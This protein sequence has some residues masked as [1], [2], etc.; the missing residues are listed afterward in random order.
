MPGVEQVSNISSHTS[1]RMN[2]SV[3]LGCTVLG[4]SPVLGASMQFRAPL[5][6]LMSAAPC[7]TRGHA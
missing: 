7:R 6:C 5:Y 4:T 2:L 1:N 3:T